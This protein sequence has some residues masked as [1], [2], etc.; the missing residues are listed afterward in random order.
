[1]KRLYTQGDKYGA[2]TPIAV[3]E[4][5]EGKNRWFLL[6]VC[7]CGTVKACRRGDLRRGFVKSC[8]CFQRE[9]PYIKHG[10]ARDYGRK[11]K[12][13]MIW[14]SMKKRC[15]P[16]GSEIEKE[17]YFARG[18]RVCERWRK[19]FE[20]FLADMGPRPSPQHT[21]DRM[22]NDGNYEPTNCRWATWL[23]QANNRRPRRWAKRPRQ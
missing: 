4:Q 23:E 1:M 19:S 10:Y 15:S 2:M 6:C 14:E 8:G 7:D 12:E 3:F 22:D 11:T 16:S 18:I 9:H 17:A 13:Y 5:G 21:L 20:N